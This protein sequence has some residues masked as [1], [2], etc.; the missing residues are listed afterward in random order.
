MRV[1]VAPPRPTKAPEPGRPAFRSYRTKFLLTV[2]PTIVVLNLLISIIFGY[3]AYDMVKQ[4]VHQKHWASIRGFASA[5]SDTLWH[6][7][8]DQ[9]RLIVE[10]MFGN[11][12]VIIVRVL[13]ETGRSIIES[14]QAGPDM[15]RL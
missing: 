3:A 13:D 9:A 7:R 12:E 6:Y 15:R 2:V 14:G 10:G 1:G 8:Y 4:E 11:N 5:L